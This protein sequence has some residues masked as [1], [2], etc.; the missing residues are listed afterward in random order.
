M[1]VDDD[2]LIHI[3]NQKGMLSHYLSNQ[4]QTTWAR[5]NNF[6]AIEAHHFARSGDAGIRTPVRR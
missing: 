2:R 1:A 6:M 5:L 3:N 4:H